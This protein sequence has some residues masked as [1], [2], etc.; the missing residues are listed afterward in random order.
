[1]KKWWGYDE[2]KA[3]IIGLLMIGLILLETLYM[4]TGYTFSILSISLGIGFSAVLIMGRKIYGFLFLGSLFGF[5]L[6]GDWVYDLS[7]Q[8]NF[9]I[10]FY[11][12]TLFIVVM[13]VGRQLYRRF[14]RKYF[15]TNN[16]LTALI[17]FVIVAL[18]V[19]ILS[20]TSVLAYC[21][22]ECEHGILRSFLIASF[23]SFSGIVFFTLFLYM[24]YRENTLKNIFISPHSIYETPLFL[25]SYLLVSFLLI[26]GFYELTVFRHFYILLAFFIFAS[27][28]Y[29]YYMLFLMMFGFFSLYGALLYDYNS[30]LSPLQFIETTALIYGFM[31]IVV[32][33]CSILKRYVEARRKQNHFLQTSN[34][35]LNK[36]IDYV[37]RFFDLSN[38]ILSEQASMKHFAK[39]TFDL[40]HFL[41]N[42]A[43]AS[44]AYFSSKGVITPVTAKGYDLERIPFL[45]ELHNTGKMESEDIVYYGNIYS[46]LKQLYPNYKVP[47]SLKHLNGASRIYTVFR[48]DVE[49][50]FI[51]GH[52]Y[53][54]GSASVENQHLKRIKDYTALLNN[55]FMKQYI[56][57][58]NR[59]IKNDIIL[60]FVRTLDLYD[61]YTKG[62][63]QDVA[64]LAKRTAT[65]LSDDKTFINDVYWAG[66]LHDIGKLGVEYDV[67]NKKGKLTDDEYDHIKKHVEYSFDVLHKNSDLKSISTMVRE[68]HERYDGLGYPRGIYQDDISLGGRIIAL[69]D[70]VA[71]M[72]TARPYKDKLDEFTIIEEIKTHAGT[73]F[74]PKIVKIMV[75]FIQDGALRE[76]TA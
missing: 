12:A 32:G 47:D 74:D 49:E 25:L 14:I 67:L 11:Q 4:P 1:M 8:K 59:L 35:Q 10:A 30:A 40:T 5:F 37:Y 20:G 33:F 70:A 66:L 23:G 62:H 42:H 48:F 76:L 17:S 21:L 18:G 75:T 68:H 53:F 44:F 15:I 26:Q 52:D 73:Q 27:L 43:D 69:C 45:N 65:V 38:D 61:H 72:A 71:T 16:F 58:Q 56:E 24:G 36:T 57:G 9:F 19:S 6:R 51:V 41:F 13:V 39:E 3:S 54:K 63:S 7:W 28:F 46:R 34:T 55:L 50:L 64:N 31:M 60:S 22:F 2:I 29:N